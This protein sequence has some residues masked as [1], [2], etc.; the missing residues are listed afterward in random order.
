MAPFDRLHTISYRSVIVSIVLSCIIIE[1]S[2]VEKYHD[3]EIKVK[4]SLTLRIYAHL[5]IAEIV[6]LGAIFAADSESLSSST[7]VQRAPDKKL[8][9]VRWWV[10]V[11]QCYEFFKLIEFVAIES[12]CYLL[13][14]FHADLLSFARYNDLLAEH[15]RLFPAWVTCAC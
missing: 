12:P 15:V 4:G 6:R 14:V 5:H 10:T 9:M 2:D 13:S 7:S 1:I 8:Y 3:L 11:V